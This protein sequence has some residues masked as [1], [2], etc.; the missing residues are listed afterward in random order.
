MRKAQRLL[1]EGRVCVLDAEHF[2]VTGDHATYLVELIDEHLL[3]CPCPSYRWR[4]RCSHRDAVALLS[5]PPDHTRETS[6]ENP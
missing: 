2:L 1:A 6:H 4:S 3:V 5:C